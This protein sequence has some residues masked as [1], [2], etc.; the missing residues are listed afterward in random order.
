MRIQ[1][2]FECDL[3]NQ[4]SD[5]YH[6]LAH[7][8]L[9]IPPGEDGKIFI[10]IPL[11]KGQFDLAVDQAIVGRVK[12]HHTDLSH[13]RLLSFDPLFAAEFGRSSASSL[14]FKRTTRYQM[15]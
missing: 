5:T 1:S 12:F 6:A 2:D 13:L 10:A 4:Q 3:C 7:F 8:T 14:Y 15:V 9:D 11:G